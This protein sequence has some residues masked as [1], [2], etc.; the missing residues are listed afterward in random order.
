MDGRVEKLRNR[1]YVERYPLCIEK[2][3]LIT[4]S[5]EMTEGEPEILRRARSL[6]NVLEN[7]TI[8][9]EEDELI[10]GN[11]ASKPMGL[12]IDHDYGTWSKEEIDSLKQEGYVISTEDEEELESLNRYYKGK[13]LVGR[14]GEIL[15][16]EERLWS[17]MQ[18]GIVLPPWK[19]KGEGSGGGYAQGGMGLGP[20]FYLLGIDFAQIL[21]YGLNSSIEV[22][23]QELEQLRF[24]GAGAVKKAYFLKAVLVAQRAIIRFAERFAE[25]AEDLFQEEE[26]PARKKEL[27]RIAETCRRVPAR[28]ARTFYEAVQF[29]W[30]LFLMITPSPTA[31]AGRFDQYMYSFY[32][33]DI[34]EDR[35]TKEEVLELLACLRIKDMQLNRVSGKQNRQKNSGMAK[36]HNWTIGGVSPEGEDAT[37]ELSYLILEAAKLCPTPH[38]TITVRVHDKTPEDFLLIAL[39]VVK[40]GIGMPAF[41]GDKSY[42]DFFVSNGM[43]LEDARE[44]IVTGCLDANI[45]G[46]SRTSSIAMFIVPRVLELTLNNGMDPSSG[47]EIGPRTGE[48]EDFTSFNDL[49]EAFKKQLAYFMG[50]NAERDN[51][52]LC[53]MQEL[54]PDPVRSSFMV[55]AIS[56]GRDVLDRTMP[57][58]NG[59]VMNPVGMVNVADSLAAIKKVV[60]EENKVT[61]P[62]LKEAL[63][64]NWQGEANEKIRK[65]FLEAPKYGNADVY[66]DQIAGK[67]YR[68]WA[69]MT[70]TLDTALGGK[71]LPTAISIT[72]HG[73]GG[74]LTGATPDGRYAGEVLA[75]GT[76]SPMRG[77]DRN[78]PTAIIKSALKIDQVP[79]QATLLNMKF[80]PSAL[81]SSEDLVKLSYLIKTY[82]NLGGKHIQFNI[83]DK[84]TLLDAQE[85]PEN[86]RDLIVRVA[87]YS[88]YFVQL[89]REVQDEIIGRVEHELGEAVK[90]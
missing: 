58:E 9:I 18:S 33:K 38:H 55:N 73:P 13:S 60:Y 21:N 10:V 27:E 61:M 5:F 81:K 44:Y 76:M 89:G 7:I 74:A 69:E 32:R 30:F 86:H 43:P 75:D 1:L 79:Y 24:T 4:E 56:E 84:E 51:I 57:F 29:F 88:A 85:H 63:I 78:G 37:N 54:L 68:F 72:A 42:I 11:V 17:F 39:E 36:W 83:V 71:H 64:A 90:Q 28:P 47:Q 22:A 6:A 26:N 87:G 48:V 15:Y 19:S 52:E 45:P 77:M 50:L 66:V 53:A 34:Q 59:A 31:A 23:E 80:H 65:M 2:F 70:G 25:L 67:L 40:A 49:F 41:I 35:L 20:G 46:K 16:D 82:F 8:F 62:Q 3:R 14:M 12:E